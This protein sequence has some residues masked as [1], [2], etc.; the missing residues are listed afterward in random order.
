MNDDVRFK[1]FLKGRPKRRHQ[2]CRQIGD[3]ADGVGKNGAHARGQVNRPHGRVQRCEQQVLRLDARLCHPVEQGRLAGVG[4]T[5]KRDH[6]MRR[7]F[8]FGAL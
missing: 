3:K 4:V 7:F 5:D 2:L 6:R 1:H 8:A